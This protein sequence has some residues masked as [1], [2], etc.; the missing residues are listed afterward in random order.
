MDESFLNEDIIGLIFSLLPEMYSSLCL[1]CKD[2]KKLLSNCGIDGW[3][4]IIAQG[5]S[6]EISSITISWFKNGLL[7]SIRDIPAF[8][9]KSGWS[10]VTAWYKN[11]KHHRENGPAVI[12]SYIDNGRRFDNTIVY[13]KNGERHREDGPARINMSFKRVEWWQ[14]GELHRDNDLPPEIYKNESG[15]TI[16]RY[17]NNGK[18]REDLPAL[19]SFN[20]YDI[21]YNMFKNNKCIHHGRNSDYYCS[22]RLNDEFFEKERIKSL[23]LDNYIIPVP[24]WVLV[25]MG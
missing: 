7:H 9:Q 16:V 14:H 12:I 24:D 11:G 25:R 2:I 17:F 18:Y 23:E 8:T 20:K 13:Y 6:I 10:I 22:S 1:V 19:I 21:A 4:A 5:V 15:Y 3:D